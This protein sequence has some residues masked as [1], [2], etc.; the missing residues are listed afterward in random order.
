MDQDRQH[1]A[2]AE[3]LSWT[4]SPWTANWRRPAAALA[5]CVIVALIGGFA[6][7]YPNYSAEALSAAEQ[8]ARDNWWVSM[9]G[10]SGL[11]LL[12]LLGM[13]AAIY[14][15][16]RYTLDARGVTTRF[17]GV[18]THRRWDHYRNFY[19]HDAGVHLTTMP[20]PSRLDPFRGHFLQFAGNRGEV[21]AFIERHMTLRGVP[22]GR[23][24]RA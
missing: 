17:L 9:I 22:E 8:A 12:L 23:E 21:V 3:A 15:P 7:T 19:V 4:A 5:L 2:E 20:Q 1:A 13:T 24:P 18:P 6:F 14:L 10:W 11:S 16:V